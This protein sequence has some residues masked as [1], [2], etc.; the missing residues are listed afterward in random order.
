MSPVS[1]EI[2]DRFFHLDSF[3]GEL[4]FYDGS[5]AQNQIFKLDSVENSYQI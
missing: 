3:P 5:V 4:R 2:H 1:N